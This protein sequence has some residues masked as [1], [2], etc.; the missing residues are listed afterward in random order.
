MISVWHSVCS[1]GSSSNQSY[2]GRGSDSLL[3]GMVLDFVDSCCS[4]HCL[5]LFHLSCCHATLKSSDT[6][7]RFLSP[8]YLQLHDQRNLSHHD[9]LHDEH[10]RVN[11]YLLRTNFAQAT[12]KYLVY[13]LRYYSHR[14]IRTSASLLSLAQTAI[15][16]PVDDRGEQRV[17]LQVR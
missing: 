17:L 8:T 14:S 13:S 10:S 3:S 7:Q 11:G 15:G 5:D 6:E 16:D 4:A 2:G 12:F 1:F 9:Q